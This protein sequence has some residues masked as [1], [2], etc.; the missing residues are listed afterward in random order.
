MAGFGIQTRNADR[1]IETD[2]LRL[3]RLGTMLGQLQQEI[4]NERAGLRGRFEQAQTSAAYALDAAE[5]GER[6]T[7]SDEAE[8]L[9][10]QMKRYQDRLTALIERERFLRDMARTVSDYKNTIAST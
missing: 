2:K 8:A 3:D 9:G 4:E 5:N 6:S 7:L 1:D 10:L